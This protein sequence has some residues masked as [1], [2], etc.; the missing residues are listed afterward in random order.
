[1]HTPN[2]GTDIDGGLILVHK[3]RVFK[4][5]IVRHFDFWIQKYLG[6]A[7]LFYRHSTINMETYPHLVSSQSLRRSK[8]SLRRAKQS[9]QRSK[10]SLRRAKQSLRRSKQSHFGE[11]MNNLFGDQSNLFGEQNNLFGDQINLF[12]DQNKHAIQAILSV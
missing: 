9:L 12:G 2:L 1:M 4:H 10:Q 6:I 7:V 11:Q 5:S 3:H 8:Q